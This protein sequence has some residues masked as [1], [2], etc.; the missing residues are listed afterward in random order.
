MD[1]LNMEQRMSC[2]KKYG[3]NFKNKGASDE[4]DG[5][6]FGFG[7]VVCGRLDLFP[8]NRSGRFG[9]ENRQRLRPENYPS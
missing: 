7:F 4:E 6:P 3:G 5:N 1:S 2:F 8:T 9:L